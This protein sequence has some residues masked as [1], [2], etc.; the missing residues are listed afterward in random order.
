MHPS[1]SVL[2]QHVRTFTERIDGLTRKGERFERNLKLPVARV[3]RILVQSMRVQAYVDGQPDPPNISPDAVHLITG[4]AYL[5]GGSLA[6]LGWDQLKK[7]DPNCSNGANLKVPHF[8]AGTEHLEEFDFLSDLIDGWTE[9]HARDIAQ[10]SQQKLQEP[11]ELQWKLRQGG[12]IQEGSP[13]T[14]MQRRA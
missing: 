3:K 5:M 7:C 8:L 12:S 4:L 6:A 14:K 1:N 11:L 9:N 13:P 2:K 10:A